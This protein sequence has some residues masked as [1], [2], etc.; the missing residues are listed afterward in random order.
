MIEAMNANKVTALIQETTLL[1]EICYACETRNF[2]YI[3]ILERELKRLKALYPLHSSLEMMQEW[4]NDA[5]E[6]ENESISEK[7]ICCTCVS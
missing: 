4:I 5:K 2:D 7:D 6:V 3:A 1:Y